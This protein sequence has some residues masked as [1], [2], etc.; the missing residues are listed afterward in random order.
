MPFPRPPPSLARSTLLQMGVRIAVIIALTTL[1][2]LPAHVPHPAHEALAQLEQHVSERGQREQ[3]IFVLAEDN[4]AV[5]KKALEER[6]RA[7]GPRRWSARF[8]SLFAQ[9]PDGTVRNRAEGFDGTRM[10]GR[11]RPPGREL[12]AELRR[13]ILASYDVLTQYGPAFHTRFTD[14]YV[15]LPEGPIIL[16]WPERPTWCLDA[17]AHRISSPPGVLHAPAARRTTRSGKTIW[18][19]VYLDRS[20]ADWMVSVSTPAGP[21]RP[22]CRD[23]SHDVLLEELMARTVNDHLPGAYN[24]L[25]RDDG[26]LIAHPDSRGRTA[27]AL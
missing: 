1:L 16:Y 4:H 8:D 3:A 23:V 15:T 12:D 5:L 2:Q 14:T 24:I 6:L 25:F 27:R 13:R 10:A 17:R 11:L 22:P 7:L 18:T 21:G 19:G 26:Q 9:L 20:A